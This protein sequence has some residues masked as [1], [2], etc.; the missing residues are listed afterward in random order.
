MDVEHSAAETRSCASVP[1]LLGIPPELSPPWGQGRRAYTSV[2]F[3]TL[4]D[5]D[6]LMDWWTSA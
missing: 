4:G 1:V 3:G 6:L 2:S 5:S